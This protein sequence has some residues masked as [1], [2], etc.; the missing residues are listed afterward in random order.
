MLEGKLPI[1]CIILTYNEE[2]N[3][4]KCLQSLYSWIGEII[5]VDSFSQDKT[6]EIAKQFTDKIY[7]NP[8]TTHVEQWIWAF[9]NVELNYEWCLA[10]DADQVVSCELKKELI[11]L[12]KNLPE[13]IDG[14]Y[15]KRRQIFRGRWIR[16]GGYYPKYL[17]RL[18]KI[19]KVFCDENELVDKHFYV[20]GKTAK[21]ENDLIEEN[22][23]ENDI[24]FWLKKHINYVELLVKEELIYKKNKKRLVKPSLFGSPEERIFWLKDIYYHLPLYI[25]AFLYFFYR[26]ILLLGFLDGKEGFLFHFLQGLWYR[27]IVDIKIEELNRA[28]YE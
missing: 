7:Q 25:R 21:L 9:N 1:S 14:F 15:I 17:L 26:Y 28:K 22:L 4:L 13:G 24:S 20:K 18:F 12:F 19:K 3:I 5:I 10:L 27:L 6:I 16:F 11:E 2:K 8:F 23:K